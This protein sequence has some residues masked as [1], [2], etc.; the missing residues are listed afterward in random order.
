MLLRYLFKTRVRVQAYEKALVF[1]HGELIDVLEPGLHW[2]G[3][4]VK[5]VKY[6]VTELFYHS[7]DLDLLLECL[8]LKANLDVV[9]VADN[10]IAIEYKNGNFHKVLE[11]GRYSFWKNGLDLRHDIIDLNSIE[12]DH[13]ISGKILQKPV[14]MK[15]LTTHVVQSYERGILH[16]DGEFVK[17]LSPGTYY[18]WKGDKNVII[19]KVDIRK[20]QIEVSGQEL[21]TSDKAS[22]RMNLFAH[23]QVK[24]IKKAL[25]ECKD[26]Y[27]QLYVILQ[28]GLREY[29]GQFSLDQLLQNKSSIAPYILEYA[30]NRVKQLGVELMD[31]GLKDIILPGDVKE[32]M[33]QVLLAEKK[34]QANLVMRR[35]ETASTRSLLNTAKLMGE[36]EML[37]KLKEMEYMEKIADKVGEITVNGGGRIIDQL[38]DLVGDN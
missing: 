19:S 31:C 1:K 29:V 10:E 14:F 3:S 6:D 15:Y 35:E 37:F 30:K 34:A 18:F 13:S 20:Q 25:V 38:R 11:P 5:I 12:V 7:I 36:N 33:N 27:R 8:P 17:E 4:F 2:V 22:I 24:D 28:L 21:L 26:H 23:Y 32:I 16:V 9:E